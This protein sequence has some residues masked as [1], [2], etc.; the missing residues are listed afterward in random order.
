MDFAFVFVV[1][2]EFV[3]F[4]SSLACMVTRETNPFLPTSLGSATSDYDSNAFFYDAAKKELNFKLLDTNP[5]EK[6]LK[7]VYSLT[8]NEDQLSEEMLSVIRQYTGMHYLKTNLNLLSSFDIDWDYT[9]KLRSIIRGLYQS[10]LR[11]V[12][13]RG[14]HLSDIEVNYFKQKIGAC[15]YTN[16]FSSFTTEKD[17]AFCGDALMILNT[18]RGNRLNVANVWKWSIFPNEME[19]ILS[20][21][22]QLKVLKVYRQE[23]R[24]IIDLEL[25]GNE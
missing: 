6:Q 24:W 7:Q 4:F 3:G 1:L 9:N 19:A 22:A 12:Y 15:Y 20:I 13:Y 21:A 5:Y 25:V 16:S 10:D 8:I 2:S 17:L 18:T 23:D 14:L 11:S